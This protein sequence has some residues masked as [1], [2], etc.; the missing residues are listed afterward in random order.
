MNIK[1]TLLSCLILTSFQVTSGHAQSLKE[2]IQLTLDENPEVQE[3]RSTRLAYE[4]EIDQAASRYLPTLDVSAGYGLEQANTPFTRGFGGISRGGSTQYGRTESSVQ[5][6][7]MVFD[8]FETP[9][10]VDRFTAK[11]DAQAYTVF[12][13]SEM[14]GLQAAQAYIGVL[15]RKALLDLAKDN[16]DTHKSFFDQIK[17]RTEQGVGRQSDLDQATGRLANA[18]SNYRAEEGNLRDADT[19]FYRVIGVLP[20]ELDDVPEPTQET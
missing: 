5:L 14:V 6:R 20:T 2:A 3:A 13:K 9:H 15:R 1:K 7:Q 18:E 10:E 4:Q 8:G 12:G 19:N 11:T 16:L 17:L